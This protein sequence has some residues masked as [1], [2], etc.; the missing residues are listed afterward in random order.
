MESG[1]QHSILFIAVTGHKLF[2]IEAKKGNEHRI[3]E[4]QNALSSKF[5]SG[6]N[7]LGSFNLS[8][9]ILVYFM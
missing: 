9:N 3:K 4:T 2:L 6:E 7:H 5:L 1:E 8:R